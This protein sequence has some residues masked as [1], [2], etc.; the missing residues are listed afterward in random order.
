M[1]K[2]NFSLVEE[3]CNHKKTIVMIKA[4]A[5]GHG[6]AE[7]YNTLKNFESLDGFG[8][9]SIEEALNLRKKTKCFKKP[10]VVFSDL[11]IK[12]NGYANDYAQN[13]IIPVLSDFPSLEFFLN[14][15]ECR[16]VPLF[17]KFNTGM[18]R[19]GFSEFDVVKI[20]KLLRRNG[21][22]HVDH[23]MSHFSDAS[24]DGL[25]NQRQLE[26]FQKIKVAFMETNERVDVKNSSISNSDAIVNGLGL[27]E[28]HVRP[29]LI[30]YGPLKKSKKI[31]WKGKMVS[32][33]R[34]HVINTFPV[35]KGDEIGYG[36]R[37]SPYEGLAHVLAIGYGDGIPTSFSEK[38]VSL[39]S[40]EAFILGRV[41]MDMT[42]IMFKDGNYSKKSQEF[43]SI[44]EN[45]PALF[46]NL[47]S[48]AGILDYE[49][50]CGLSDRVSRVYKV[51]D[52]ESLS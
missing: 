1:L 37:P 20:K 4:N 18:N 41:N 42:L 30:L 29:G 10:I 17:L 14:S 26:C 28:T 32:Q 21:R 40:G 34:T 45:D 50:L 44:W 38:I 6:D 22:N 25:K 2:K 31:E 13:K 3:I 33:L 12:D 7:V 8:V 27:N 49:L 39:P 11:F 35:K 5:Y 23:L 24:S 46:S 48:C 43:I 51:A 19:L 47:S 52:E 9:A 16:G 36:S 15:V